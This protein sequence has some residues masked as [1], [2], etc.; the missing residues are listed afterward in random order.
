MPDALAAIRLTGQQKQ[1]LHQ[2]EIPYIIGS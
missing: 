2:V 1:L